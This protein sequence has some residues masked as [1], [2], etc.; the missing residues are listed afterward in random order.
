VGRT[1]VRVSRNALGPA[2][3]GPVEALVRLLGGA[4]AAASVR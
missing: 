4:P 1:Q 3:L 2:W